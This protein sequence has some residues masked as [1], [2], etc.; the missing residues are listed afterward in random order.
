MRRVYLDSCAVDPFLDLPGALDTARSAV[1]RGDLELLFS[2]V[3]WDE[4]EATPD[5]VRREGLLQVL[6]EVGTRIATGSIVFGYSRFNEARFSATSD[7]HDSFGGRNHNHTRDAM[8]AN[9][10]HVENCE[11]ITTE[12]KRMRNAAARLGVTVVHPLDLLRDIGWSPT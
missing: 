1:E 10:A 5:P 6:R 4:V 3:T 12:L 9:T 8:H 2:H 11:L 7:F